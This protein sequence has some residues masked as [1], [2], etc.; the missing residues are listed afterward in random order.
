MS[1]GFRFRLKRKDPSILSKIIKKNEIILKTRN[2]FHKTCP[3]IIVNN[4]K[5]VSHYT[6]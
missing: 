5:A 3:Q 1:E 4:L 2:T 6:V